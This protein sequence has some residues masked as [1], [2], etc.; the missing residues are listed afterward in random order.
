VAAPVISVGNLTVGGT[1]KTPLVAWLAEW[2][3]RRQVPVTIISRGYGAKAGKPNDEALELAFRLPEARQLQNPDRVAAAEEALQQNAQQVLVLD[4]AFQH[5]R[6]A[7]DL[8]IVLLDALEPFGYE[9]LLPR[10]LLREPVESLSRAQVVA[11][12]RSDAI[13]ADQ[14]QAIEK[15]VR[16][17]APNVVWLEM[18]HRPAGLAS[19]GGVSL[20][21]A[22]LAKGQVAVFCGIGNPAGFRHTLTQCGIQPCGFLE[23]P[24]HCAYSLADLSRITTWLTA[25]PAAQHVVCTRKDL[26]KIPQ[27]NL[28]GKRLWALEIELEI[29]RGQDE[30]EALLEKIHHQCDSSGR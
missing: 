13:T 11:L 12:S 10:G 22:E 30:L 27:G 18:T 21:F 4:D 19:F 1:G 3:A 20:D 26:V 8:D 2:F 9:R 28:A 25:L 15:R 24:D 23:L 29:N 17:I 6:L 16:G 5:R 14:R 7:R